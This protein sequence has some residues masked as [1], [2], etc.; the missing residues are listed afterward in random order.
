MVFY[1]PSSLNLPNGERCLF[2]SFRLQRQCTSGNPESN[3]LLKINVEVHMS[4]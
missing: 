3:E 1:M 2:F 4:M